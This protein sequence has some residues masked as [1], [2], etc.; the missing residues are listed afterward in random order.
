MFVAALNLIVIAIL[1]FI[2]TLFLSVGVVWG[3]AVGFAFAIGWTCSTVIWQVAHR[4]R[5][6]QFFGPPKVRASD[7]A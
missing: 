7:S 2:A 3:A 1:L 6:G 4:V 5:Y